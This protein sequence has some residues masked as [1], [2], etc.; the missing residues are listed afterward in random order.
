MPTPFFQDN[1]TCKMSMITAT[2]WVPRG[3]AAAFPT[4]YVFDDEEYGRIAKLAK[5]QLDD[6]EEDL[7]EAKA[8]A[9]GESSSKSSKGVAGGISQL[10]LN[11]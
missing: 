10:Q 3:H 11:E 9:N 6:A 8:T 1:R 7:A 5:L 4:K 2:T